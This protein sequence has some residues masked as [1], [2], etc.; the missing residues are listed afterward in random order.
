[1]KFELTY[2][3]A[4]YSGEAGWSWEVTVQGEVVAKAPEVYEDEKAARS[5][6]AKARKAFGGYRFAKVIGP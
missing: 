5:A 4:S 3:E 1:M 2:D 6:I